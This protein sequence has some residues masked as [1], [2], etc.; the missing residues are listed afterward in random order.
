MCFTFTAG[1]PPLC[2]LLC[3]QPTVTPFPHSGRRPSYSRCAALLCCSIAI[4]ICFPHPCCMP[5]RWQEA[6]VQQ[7]L[8][9]VRQPVICHHLSILNVTCSLSLSIPFSAALSFAPMLPFLPH[10]TTCKAPSDSVPPVSPSL[11]QCSCIKRTARTLRCHRAN[12]TIPWH[13]CAA[14]G[15]CCSCDDR[16]VETGV[17][18]VAHC[19]LCGTSLDVSSHLSHPLS[20]HC[21]LLKL[22]LQC[23][24]ENK[25]LPHTHRA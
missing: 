6:I 16:R 2:P 19:L 14:R 7:V 11:G 15:G 20:T 13:S 8:L 23:T 17:W 9:C 5:T 1:T 21:G 3:L 18:C 12:H 4:C 25:H 10:Q 24:H 22:S